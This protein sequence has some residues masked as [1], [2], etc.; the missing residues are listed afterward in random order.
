MFKIRFQKSLK[1]L[2]KKSETRFP[3][4][5]MLY[6]VA[7]AVGVGLSPNYKINGC[8]HR[9][10]ILCDGAVDSNN[11]KPSHSGNT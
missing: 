4:I 7:P 5:L 11:L 9:A 8:T 3:S 10:M 1:E 2:N 6:L